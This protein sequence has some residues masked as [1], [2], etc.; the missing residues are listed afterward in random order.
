M[1]AAD[2]AGVGVG[3]LVVGGVRVG[4]LVGVFIRCCN[5]LSALVVLRSGVRCD[6]MPPAAKTCEVKGGNAKERGDL[7]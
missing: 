4:V 1:L 7:I 6:V 5:F 2:A 3:V